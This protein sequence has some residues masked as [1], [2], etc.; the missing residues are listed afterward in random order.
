MPPYVPPPPPPPIAPCIGQGVSFDFEYSY[1]VYNNLGGQGPV[2]T[3]P[4][5]MR[6]A[7]VGA[8][9]FGG[10]DY[11]F[12]IE[13]TTAGGYTP[14]DSSLNG[15]VNNQFAQI[16][17]ACNHDV[18]IKAKLMYSCATAP[19]CRKCEESGF[20]SALRVSC[21]A[22]GCSCYGTTV[23]L[24]A[25]CW[26]PAQ[27]NAYKQQYRCMN[28]DQVIV[29][30]GDALASLSVYD[31]DTDVTG[32]VLEQLT[33]PEYAYYKM[34]LRPWSYNTI[35]STVY[36]NLATRTFTGTDPGAVRHAPQPNPLATPLPAPL[37]R[38]FLTV[39]L[40]HRHAGKRRVGHA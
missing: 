24:Q 16:N 39:V 21:Y 15:Y 10:R 20:S 23:Y 9:Y 32:E 1:L 36:A 18:T 26:Q 27:F 22:I 8:M 35:T 12:D 28:K 33:V 31:L 3:D 30:P 29:L 40:E 14:Y 7:N 11:Y 19:S 25:D 38:F 2:T 5:V 4:S 6:F 17:L 13:L 34:P 37:A